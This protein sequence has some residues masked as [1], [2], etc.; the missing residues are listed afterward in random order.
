MLSI[1]NILLLEL[2]GVSTCR[3]NAKLVYRNIRVLEIFVSAVLWKYDIREIREIDFRLLRS[4]C[5]VYVC[6]CVTV[7]VWVCHCECVCVC[8]CVSACECVWVSLCECA[9]V[10]VSVWV[11]VCECVCVSVSLWV[12][13]CV[14]VC[15]SVCLCNT[16]PTFLNLNPLWS[17][18]RILMIIYFSVGAA[19]QHWPWPPH[20]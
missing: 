7:S 5:C 13:E 19:A 15:L 2:Y 10:T 9:C 12:C 1:R 3:R 16:L 18:L 20:S 8:E 4:V 17:V 6:E 11:C 14:C